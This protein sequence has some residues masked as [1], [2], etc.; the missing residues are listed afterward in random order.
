[1]ADT[2]LILGNGFDVAMGRKQSIQI[3]LNLNRDYLLNQIV[4]YE[5]F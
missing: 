5:P 1:M 3:L 2:I 4:T